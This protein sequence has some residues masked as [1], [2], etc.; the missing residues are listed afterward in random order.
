PADF[1]I[2]E[3]GVQQ[4]IDFFDHPLNRESGKSA[5]G[6]T[7]DPASA[8]STPQ[9]PKSRGPRNIIFLVLDRQTIEASNMKHVREGVIKYIREQIT[10]T[11]MVGLFAITGGL[12]LLAPFT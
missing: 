3:N 12:Q 1:T 8:G 10:D 5:A 2:L 4:R 9:D 6:N 11:D 7:T